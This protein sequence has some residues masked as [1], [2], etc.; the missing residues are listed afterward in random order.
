MKLLNA[1]IT[2]R[3]ASIPILDA[4]TFREEERA[5]HDL[6]SIPGVREVILTQTCNRVEIWAALD[7]ES[8]K[9]SSQTVLDYWR[10]KA[11]LREESF[12]RVIEVEYDRDAIRH[13]FR[14]ASGVE[15]ML[16]GEEQILGQVRRAYQKAAQLKAAGRYLGAVFSKAI[17]V[18]RKARVI[19]G[20][21]KGAV[22]IGSAAVRLMER[23]LGNLQRRRVIIVGA[24]ETGELVGKAL[25][26]RKGAAI[27]V[28]NRTYERGLRLAS[29]LDGRAVRFDRIPDFLATVDVA[30]VA[31][32]APHYV[33]T[34]DL[35][36]A[37]T[38]DRRSP[39]LIIDLS[40][41]ANVDPAV[42]SVPRV[43]L[44]NLDDLRGV[45][46]LNLKARAREVKKVEEFVERELGEFAS[47][48]RRL[49]VE[50]LIA[51]ICRSAENLRVQE[52]EKLRS[53]LE[54]DEDRWLIVERFS[55]ELVETILRAPLNA[56]RRAAIHEDSAI[57]SVAHEIFGIEED[58]PSGK[59]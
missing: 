57:V 15:S 45:A 4:V 10:K 19:T 24:G 16:I 14:V 34:R 56:I 42:M 36:E 17:R 30:V 27:F 1:R 18:G 25:A 11:K 22:S 48:L 35:A 20:I 40:Q 39:L 47:Y 5:L 26:A 12:R 28:A 51:A 38:K 13:L 52:L 8:W 50:P 41:P 53:I 54:L 2:H 3:K 9:E 44:L 46:E 21:S 31:T 33:I 55:Q 32:A 58:V 43:K 23:H 6:A 59:A 7:D 29:L 37:A 49:E